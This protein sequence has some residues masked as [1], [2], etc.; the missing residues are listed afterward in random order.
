MHRTV[1]VIVGTFL[2]ITT[3]LAQ[4]PPPGP[5]GLAA[6]LQVLYGR[7]KPNLMQA[8][9]KMPASD[10]GFKATQ[11]IRTYGAQLGHAANFH[12]T[13]CSAVKGEA[14]PMEGQ[15]LEQK[16]TK[17]EFVKVLGDAFAYCDGL[18]STLTDEN[19]LKMVTGPPGAPPVARGGLLA[20]L[21]THDNEVYGIVT[22]YLRLKGLVP[23]ST[24]NEGRA[25]GDGRGGG[26]Q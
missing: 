23:P 26:G 12:Y 6:Y 2:G 8:A 22:V 16:T 7:V 10:Y 9:E 1:A 19:M 11:E 15:N 25:R 13:V 5:V 24:E 14:N 4:T 3:T 21:L 17:A 20:N 18:F